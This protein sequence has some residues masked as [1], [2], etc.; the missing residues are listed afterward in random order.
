MKTNHFK[1]YL[2]IFGTTYILTVYRSLYCW[3]IDLRSVVVVDHFRN[4]KGIYSMANPRRMVYIIDNGAYTYPGRK[5]KIVKNYYIRLTRVLNTISRQNQISISL[6][7]S[8]CIH[9]NVELGL[10]HLYLKINT[11]YHAKENFS[12][13]IYVKVVK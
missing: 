7:L 8:K 5:K 2:N 12:E 3:Q 11:G 10:Q 9:Q 1:K 6:K 13:K 4:L